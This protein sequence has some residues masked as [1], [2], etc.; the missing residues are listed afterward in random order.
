MN[1]KSGRC[2]VVDVWEV[3]FI[4]EGRGKRRF[5]MYSVSR[6]VLIQSVILESGREGVTRE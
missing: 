6:N 3:W 2:E 4:G 1:E 5:G